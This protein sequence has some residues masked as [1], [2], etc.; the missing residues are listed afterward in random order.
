MNQAVQDSAP[1][2]KGWKNHVEE[3]RITGLISA[4]KGISYEVGELQHS[5]NFR[6]GE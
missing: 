2:M 6:V 3:L 1:L 5:G 4:I